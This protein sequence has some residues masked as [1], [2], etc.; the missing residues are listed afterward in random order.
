MLDQEPEKAPPI[1]GGVFW[2]EVT[3][4]PQIYPAA[5]KVL[6]YAEHAFA[7]LLEATDGHFGLQGMVLVVTEIFNTAPHPK[8]VEAYLLS[9]LQGNIFNATA[10]ASVRRVVEIA[11]FLLEESALFSN[12]LFRRF[13]P[14]PPGGKIAQLLF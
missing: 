6:G 9:R 10:W 8:A 7:R 4:D 2:L 5:I 13:S 11:Y 3:H 1:L 12:L 14:K